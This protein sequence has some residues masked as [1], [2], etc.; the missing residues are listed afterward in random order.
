MPRAVQTDSAARVPS[1]S[2]HVREWSAEEFAAARGAWTELLVDS[3]A[4]PLFMSWFWQRAWMSQFVVPSTHNARIL[5]LY[6]DSGRL[7][8]LAPMR[9]GSRR[10]R[11]VVPVRRLTFLAGDS[12][13][14]DGMMTEYLGFILRRG[15]EDPAADALARACLGLRG[16]DDAWFDLM[17]AQSATLRALHSLGGVDCARYECPW[18]YMNSYRI[19]TDGADFDAY[20]QALSATTRRRLFHLRKRLVKDHGRPVLE[21]AESDRVEEFIDELNALH[22]L[23]WS[24]DAFTGRCRTFILQMC[25]EKAQAGELALS[26]LQLG[27]A[28]RS[29]LLN[30][31]AGSEEYNIQAGFDPRFDT[32]L[33]LGYLHLGYAIE[34]AFADPRVSAIDLLAGGGKNSNYKAALATHEV[35]LDTLQV[36]RHP[37]LRIAYGLW[38]SKPSERT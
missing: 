4:H 38:R 22:A 28:T 34:G 37:A 36:V 1:G 8:G 9:F 32:K 14:L 6:A 26:R 19:A 7:V 2:L 3:D 16:W 5:A 12:D 25:R 30:L 20:K 17:P 27:G 15:W 21:Y 23:R 31:R 13:R 33:P 18:G 24:E 29:V 11:G 35:R 10:L